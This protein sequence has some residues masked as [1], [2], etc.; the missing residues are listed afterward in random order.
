[1]INPLPLQELALRKPVLQ[2]L[3]SQMFVLGI[4]QMLIIIE[5]WRCA[6]RKDSKIYIA[7]HKGLTGSAILENLKQKGYQN[8]VLRTHKELDLT[9][10]REVEEFLKK[11]NQNMCFCALQEWAGLSQTILIEQILFMKT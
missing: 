7:G 11:R 5:L 3:E 4:L 1:M 10:Q 2:D 6:V 9:R 8:F